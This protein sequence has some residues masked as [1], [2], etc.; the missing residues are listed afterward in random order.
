PLTPQQARL[1][2]KG[3][4]VE[5]VVTTLEEKLGRR[6]SHEWVY[7]WGMATALGLVRGLRAVPGVRDIVEALSLKGHPMCVASQ[8]PPAR[9]ALSLLLTRLD[10]FFGSRIYT[11]SMVT[12]PKPAPD[13]FLHAAQSCG[14]RPQACA[15]VE[16][17]PSG[18]VAAVAAGMVAFGFA[19][20]ED[21]SHLAAAGAKV[22]HSMHELRTLL[23][24]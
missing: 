19:A 4:T 3:R 13:L 1:L 7:D 21:A 8:S 9:V 14:V 12:H 10:G 15:V 2:F 17:S 6:L 16:D 5:G 20:E 23:E 22:F 11:A 18:V 24:L